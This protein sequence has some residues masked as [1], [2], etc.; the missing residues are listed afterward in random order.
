MRNGAIVCEPPSNIH[1]ADAA[2]WV[3][4]YVYGGTFAHYR[5]FRDAIGYLGGRVGFVVLK[6]ACRNEGF[7]EGGNVRGANRR[8]VVVARIAHARQLWDDEAGWRGPEHEPKSG[9]FF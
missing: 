5:I 2:K 7:L 9:P 3:K 8:M 6:P 4:K 1:A